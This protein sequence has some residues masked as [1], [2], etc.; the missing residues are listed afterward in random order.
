MGRNLNPI[1]ND[2]YK[3]EKQLGRGASGF[4]Y[5]VWDKKLKRYVAAKV[6]N[7]KNDNFVPEVMLAGRLDHENIVAIYDA[8]SNMDYCYVIMEYIQGTTLSS[9]CKKRDLLPPQR[10]CEV[11][12]GVCKGLQYA[13][14]KNVIHKDIKPSNIILNKMGIPKISDFGIAQMVERTMPLGLWG[15]PGYMSPEQLNGKVLTNASDIFSLGSVLYELLE[16]K[17]AFGNEN[18]YSI[19]YKIMH[20]KPPKLSLLPTEQKELFEKII[21]KALAKNPASRYQSCHDL[22]YDLSRA[23]VS[24]NRKKQVK[25]QGILSA[26]SSRI[27]E[28]IPNPLG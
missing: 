28:H 5:K 25:N 22:A 23:L 19:I 4:V 2:R 17:K 11:I 9:F 21:H 12:I 8:D 10:I 16:G 14:S 7:K 1:N 3:F 13:H 18:I 15:T 6:T 24:I 26:I 27:R 20:D